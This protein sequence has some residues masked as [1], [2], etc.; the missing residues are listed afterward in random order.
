MTGQRLSRTEKVLF[1]TTFGLIG[2]L[3]STSILAL[4]LFHFDV[5]TRDEWALYNRYVTW[6]F[7]QAILAAR[8][9]HR[10]VL[11]GLLQYA[12][13]I[14]LKAHLSNLIIINVTLMVATAWLLTW[15][16]KKLLTHRSSQWLLTGLGLVALLW[17]GNRQAM[18]WAFALTYTLGIVGAVLACFSM[19]RSKR[20]ATG[21]THRPWLALALLSAFVATF[22]WGGGAAIWPVLILMAWTQRA[23]RKTRLAV[24]LTSIVVIAAYLTPLPGDSGLVIHLPHSFLTAV[25]I[26][27][28]TLGVLGNMPSH[29]LA[30]LSPIPNRGPNLTGIGAGLLA[31]LLAGILIYLWWIKQ[32]SRGELM[33]LIGIVLFCIGN[34]LIMGL[35]RY[36]PFVG[37]SRFAAEEKRASR[38]SRM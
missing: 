13:L 4:V 15:D 27:I 24:V 18:I 3:L 19:A 36:D 33:P 38:N 11:P 14:W 31:L 30:P 35:A 9:G 34:A 12:N 2:F 7:W 22:S 16:A 6:P 37:R 8:N 23:S 32:S 5:V 28:E 10:L 29:L 20:T 17:L 1:A 26:I 21:A 25:Q